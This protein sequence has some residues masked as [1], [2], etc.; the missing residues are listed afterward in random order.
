LHS[1]LHLFLFSSSFLFLFSHF[2]FRSSFLDSVPAL[3]WFTL[4]APSSYLMGIGRNLIESEGRFSSSE[5]RGVMACV[6]HSIK[7]Q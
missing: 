4:H 2:L 7:R 1:L 3:H 5:W 6:T